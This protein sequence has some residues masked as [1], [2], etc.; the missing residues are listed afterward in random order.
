M[1]P[2]SN[3]FFFWVYCRLQLVPQKNISG[4]FWRSFFHSSPNQQW[5]YSELKEL[6][7]ETPNREHHPLAQS[8]HDPSALADVPV[9]FSS[10]SVMCTGFS[11]TRFHDR[12][13]AKSKI[14]RWCVIGLF[15][16][17]CCFFSALQTRTPLYVAHGIHVIYRDSSCPPTDPCGKDTTPFVAA[18][19]CWCEFMLVDICCD[20]QESVERTQC[21]VLAARGVTALLIQSML[22]PNC[23]NP[24]NS[25]Y[26]YCPRNKPLAFFTTRSVGKWQLDFLSPL[27]WNTRIH[28]FYGPIGF[29]LG[30][31]KWAGTRKVKPGR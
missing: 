7:A 6:K 20:W 17:V 1:H 10:V 28:P 9:H 30:P 15:T 16:A 25:S 31:L 12:H 5:R 23:G 18:V 11:R 13:I 26:E 2:V 27:W 19:W 22:T 3:G 24:T 29:C 21:Q 14:H 4:Y 8:L